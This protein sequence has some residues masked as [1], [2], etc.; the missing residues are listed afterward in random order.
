MPLLI[1]GYNLLYATGIVGRGSG[2]GGLERSRLALLNFLA[3]SIDP[4]DL[5]HTTVVFDAHDAP[6]GL[7]RVVRHRGITV[8]YAA[9]YE[10][11]DKLIAELIRTDSAPR[12]LVVVSSD[13]E[14]Q[15]AARRRRAKTVASDDWYA[16]LL[17]ARQQRAQAAAETPERP[18]VPLLAEDVEYWVR[19]FGGESALQESAE[20]P[21]DDESY[22]PFPPGYGDDVLRG[23]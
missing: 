9:G 13:H 16:E 19:Q 18:S 17:R 10:T 1:D 2:P 23:Q 8:R 11:A 20:K 3:H 14:I 7:P 15:R 22:N 21:Q 12:R 4:A 6:R 5:P